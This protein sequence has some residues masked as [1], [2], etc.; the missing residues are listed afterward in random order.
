MKHALRITL[1]LALYGLYVYLFA[2]WLPNTTALFSPWGTTREGIIHFLFALGLIWYNLRAATPTIR[3]YIYALFLAGFAGLMLAFKLEGYALMGWG[4][5]R[6]TYA[7]ARYI[8]AFVCVCLAALLPL[9]ASKSPQGGSTKVG[10]ALL[11]GAVLSF[12]FASAFPNVGFATENDLRFY[13]KY[14]TAPSNTPIYAFNEG[15]EAEFVV[16]RV[17]SVDC[18]TYHKV[19]YHRPDMADF[20]VSPTLQDTIWL[21]VTKPQHPTITDTNHT[22]TRWQWQYAAWEWLKSKF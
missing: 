21:D 19:L 16:L 7:T 12:V 11:Y 4:E 10:K 14:R 9:S 13:L 15:K 22:F 20:I 8:F 18:N 5:A 17:D 1:S 3:H 6:D 2:Y